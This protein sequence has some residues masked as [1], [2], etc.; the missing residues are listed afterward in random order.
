MSGALAKITKT[1]ALTAGILKDSADVIAREGCHALN[2]HRVGIWRMSNDARTLESI[3]SYNIVTDELAVQEAFPLDQRREYVKFLTNERLI[4]ISDIEKPNVLSDLREDYGPQICAL[5]DAPVRVGGKLVG[6]VCIEQDRCEDF[7]EK[8]EW[9]IEEQNFAS[10]LADFTALAMESAERRLLMR[11][12]ETLMSNLPGMVYQCLNDP[13]DFTFTFVSEGCQK[14]IGYTAEELVNNAVK[15]FD[16]VH[17]DDVD[18]LVRINA[19]TLSIGLPL[20]TT[21]R[22]IM[23]DGSV[24]WIWERSRVVERNPNGSPRLLEGFYT[25]ITEQ[26]RLEAAELA[27]RAKSEFLANMSHEIRTPMNAILGMTDL[28]LRSFPQKTVLEYLKNIKSAGTALLSIIN[29]ILDF[30]KIEA[31]AV[32]L[33]PDKYDI[34]S[35]I[36]DVVT[37]IHIRIGDKPLDF[38]VD[39]DPSMPQEMVGDM[40][41]I[42]QIAVNLLTNAVKF[43]REGHV[44]FSVGAEPAGGGRYKLKIAVRDTGIGIRN[45]EI[46]L[47]FGNFSQLDTRKNRGIEGT[48]L[49]LAISKKLV[50]LMDGEIRVESVYGEGSCF[51]F[52][53]MQEVEDLK[54]AVSLP[55]DASRRAAI[56]FANA[57]KA[58]ALAEKLAKMKVSCDIVDGPDDFGQ[59]S[60]AFF[61]FD[62]YDRVC[63]VPCPK[64]QLIAV[65]R[66]A[67]DE[68]G[69][70]SHVKTVSMPF[71][72][73]SAAK[74]LDERTRGFGDESSR[75]EE[76]SSLRLR[77]VSL[78][79]VDDNEINLVIAENALNLY[80]GKVSVAQSGAEAVELV[81][82]NDY[83]IVFMDHM[84]PEMDGVDATQIIRAL[85]DE[86]YRR[87]PIVALTANVVGDVR[88]MFLQSGMNDFL[89]KPLEFHEIERVLQ[90][91]LPRGKW[92]RVPRADKKNG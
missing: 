71:T 63:G 43:T 6:V 31:G 88:D 40:T 16:M 48:G 3:V 90:E 87:L 30:S 7:P 37:M 27:N 69:L 5:L 49:G 61:D 50:G 75:A 80:G 60:H 89:S 55:E 23:K 68:Q 92:E 2:T 57:V 32:E 38:I 78:L 65:S 4:V 74:L 34:R 21:F 13:P 14:L 46:P 25:D 24:K 22:M 62:Q 41:R 53:V 17:P 44:T 8:R 64:T 79:V 66:S 77:D 54:P 67:I 58:E 76:N 11:R 10:S 70:P 83:D 91:W 59:Y 19:E 86:K 29:D 12:T 18:A 36:N 20:E 35:F 81:K 73:L 39:D 82:R 1:P 45:E 42:K 85:P 56:W 26:R 15:F 9:T 28:A 84:M 47:L 72:C 52:Y 51:S 33:I